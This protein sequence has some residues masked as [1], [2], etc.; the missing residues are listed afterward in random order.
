[1]ERARCDGFPAVTMEGTVVRGDGRGRRLGF[2][3]ANLRLDPDT[4]PPLGVFAARVEGA[5]GQVAAVANI[6]TRPTFEGQGVSVEVHLLDFEGD[7]YDRRLRVTLHRRL[8]GERRFDTVEELRRQ[9]AGD[10]EQA[11]A[12]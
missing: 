5:G 7:L 10:I 11:R 12:R 2:P 4:D 1:M 8:R 6:G 3:T 9:I